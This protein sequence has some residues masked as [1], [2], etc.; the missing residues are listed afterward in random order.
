MGFWRSRKENFERSWNAPQRKAPYV[1]K[2]ISKQKSPNRVVF[3]R[4]RKEIVCI[5]NENHKTQMKKIFFGNLPKENVWE[6]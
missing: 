6:N 3:G 2:I 1:F 4:T 5:R